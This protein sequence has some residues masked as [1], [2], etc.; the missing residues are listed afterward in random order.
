MEGNEEKENNKIKSRK[1]EYVKGIPSI[2]ISK[3]ALEKRN[4][5]EVHK[6]RSGSSS[7]NNNESQK[8]LNIGIM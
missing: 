8:I 4:K 3:C 2:L 1:S 7:V 6:E 5:K